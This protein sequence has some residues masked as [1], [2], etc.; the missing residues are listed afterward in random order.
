MLAAAE[1]FPLIEDYA[2]IG[3][4]RSVALISRDGS[5][6]W[7]C[8]PR[9]DSPSF[10]AALLDRTRGGRFV[11]RPAGAFSSERRYIG[12][13]NVL[14]T[15]FRAASGVARL[16][17]V[18]PVDSEEAKRRKLYPEHQLLRA[19][20]CL[21]G[22]VTFEMECDPRPNY[23]RT[24]PRMRDRGT[25]G[26]YYEHRG[27]L[28]SVRSDVPLALNAD[29]SAVHARFTLS[30]GERRYVSLVF[31]DQ[32]PAV[33]PPLGAEAA[34]KI[35]RSIAWWDA[36]S[37]RCEYDGR[38]R[39][40]V[41][42]SAL[43]LK[44]LT[45]APSGAVVAAP[46]TSL[47]EWLGG[48][49]NWDYRF[50]WLRDASLTVQAL[51][52]LGYADEGNS[53][54]AWLLHATR[55]TRPKLNVMYDVYGETDLHERELPHLTGYEGS[56][57][58]R[59]GN[60]A[61]DQLQL[62]IYGELIDA[63]YEFVCRGGH[64]DRAT[65]RMLVGLGDTVCRMWREADEGIWE[66]RGGRRQHTYSKTM[67]WLALDR[68]LR[69]HQGGHLHLPDRAYATERKRIEQTIEEQGFNERLGS[70]VATLGGEHVDASLLRLARHGYVNPSSDRMRSTVRRI[71]DTLGHDGLIYRYRDESDGLPPGEGAFGI[72]SFWA[73][74]AQA[75]GGDVDAAVELFERMLTYANDVGLYAEEI[76]PDSGRFLGNF[77]QAFTHVGLIDAALTLEHV[78][79]THRR[80]TE[81]QPVHKTEAHV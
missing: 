53:F 67:C 41:I 73:V 12:H 50:C 21:D 47:P 14:E 74:N 55:L 25:L 76:D 33:I 49:R 8:W 71:L 4:C 60:G 34:T 15:T 5:I 75:L 81:E 29:G 48:V 44:L 52:D 59:I 30:R 32:E 11:I 77:P 46:T 42:R 58:V 43:T 1:A 80:S 56:R 22:E 3:D 19:V 26:L 13:T 31:S 66:S 36:W 38:Y 62:D 39:D 54:M 20:E 37:A 45:F 68:L 35:E 40:M 16:I 63:V 57:P 69:L 28:L 9:F 79:G 24:V 7:L 23:A 72:C 64:L 65:R 18:M 70:Y 51:Y 6:D 61:H 10:F 17:D 27:R 2:I 78:A